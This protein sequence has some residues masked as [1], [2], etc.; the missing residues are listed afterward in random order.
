MVAHGGVASDLDSATTT[1]G[2]V[3]RYTLADGPMPLAVWG[4][5]LFP[6]MGAVAERALRALA[7]ADLGEVGTLMDENQ[8][9][10][11]QLGVSCPEIERLTAAARA[12][13]ALG[14]KLSGSG[15]GGIIIALA[16]QE[17][18]HAV[19]GAVEAAG[20][21]AIMAQAG[22]PGASADGQVVS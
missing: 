21:R 12:A 10:L 4:A 9:L 16:T 15:G 1:L 18:Q 7:S 20:G 19:A 8:A 13:G 5:R 11:E 17:T 22:G 6:M 2:G 3:V 14:A